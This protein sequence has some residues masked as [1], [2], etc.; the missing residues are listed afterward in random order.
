VQ[1]AE[2]LSIL[3]RLKDLPVKFFVTEKNEQPVDS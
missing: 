1:T 3:K 2:Q